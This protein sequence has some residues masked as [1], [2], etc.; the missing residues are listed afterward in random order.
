MVASGI[1]EKCDDH[2]SQVADLALE[3]RGTANAAGVDVRIGIH[4]G[5]LVAGVLGTERLMYD[6]WGPTVNLASRLESS[7]EAGT[8]AVSSEVEQSLAGTHE[9][10]G[11]FEMELKGIGSTS[12]WRLKKRKVQGLALS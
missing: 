10:D 9:F 4:S 2:I 5:P 7:A 6:L 11:P 3:L 1:P 12:V 8:I